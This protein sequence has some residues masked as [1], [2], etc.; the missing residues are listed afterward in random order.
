MH[1]ARSRLGVS[2]IATALYVSGYSDHALLHRGAI[3]QGTA[4]LQK[5][6][7]PESLLLKV[8]ELLRAEVNVRAAARRHLCLCRSVRTGRQVKP[9]LGLVRFPKRCARGAPL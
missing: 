7:L 3:K 4:L 2:A 8:D 6:F 9:T 1:A 5:P